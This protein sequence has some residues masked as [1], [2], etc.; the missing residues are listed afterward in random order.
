[1][2]DTAIYK[3]GF[4]ILIVMNSVLIYL[5]VQ[6]PPKPA[7]RG[8]DEK[9]FL[10][11]KISKQLDLNPEQEAKYLKLVEKHQI[12]MVDIEKEQQKLTKRYFKALNDQSPEPEQQASIMEQLKELEERKIKLTYQH[13]E[14]LKTICTP[15]QKTGF[16]EILKEIIQV[17][18]SKEKV[19]PVPPP[20]EF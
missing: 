11:T 18:T 13:F 1:M 14:A 7:P 6:N 17:M 4:V 20:R 9:P 16:N 15:G 2:R 5:L 10:A 8:S 12:Q 19:S 3:I